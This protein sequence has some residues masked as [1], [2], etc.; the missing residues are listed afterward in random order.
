MASPVSPRCYLPTIFSFAVRG[1]QAA[2]DQR[3]VHTTPPFTTWI[4]ALRGA[5]C[6]TSEAC[7]RRWFLVK[8]LTS[9]EQATARF[10]GKGN[11]R[12]FP[13]KFLCFLTVS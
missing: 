1:V 12:V 7:S 2:P 8:H 10:L 9:D 13:A 6:V 4:T 5:K 3:A 11:G